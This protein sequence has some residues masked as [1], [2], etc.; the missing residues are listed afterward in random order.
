MALPGM[1]LHLCE[2]VRKIGGGA[3]RQFESAGN[4]EFFKEVIA[5]RLDRLFT[6]KESFGDLLVS[7]AGTDV[8]EDI[9]FLLG[10]MDI[11]LFVVVAA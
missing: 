7:E 11:V 8:I 2:T 5:V 10:Q 9:D 3:K 4:A 6:D 1:L